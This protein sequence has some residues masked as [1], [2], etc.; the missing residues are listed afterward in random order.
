MSPTLLKVLLP[1]PR[2]SEKGRVR[3]CPRPNRPTSTGDGSK[4]PGGC[5]VTRSGDSQDVRARKMTPPKI[6]LGRLMAD[7]K[8]GFFIF[9]RMRDARP[10]QLEFTPNASLLKLIKV[11]VKVPGT[12]SNTRFYQ[13]LSL[14][15]DPCSLVAVVHFRKVAS[16]LT[17]DL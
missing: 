5:K 1:S 12:L 17:D 14:S 10:F 2:R 15:L 9:W 11:I 8:K 16:P 4:S 3:Q 6:Q 13:R 7:I